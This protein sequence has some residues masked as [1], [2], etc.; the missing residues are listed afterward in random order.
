ML[1]I[2]VQK[3]ESLVEIYMWYSAFTQYLLK[4]VKL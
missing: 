3:Q 1:V 4:F 2:A